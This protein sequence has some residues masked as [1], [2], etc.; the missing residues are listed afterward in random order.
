MKSRHQKY[1]AQ[2]MPL[3]P[4]NHVFVLSERH[5]NPWHI[6]QTIRTMS[7]QAGSIQ[8][9]Y[10]RYFIVRLFALLRY[11]DIV[12]ISD[13]ALNCSQKQSLQIESSLSN[14]R[15][16]LQPRYSPD[17]NQD[18]PWPHPRTR[19]SSKAPQAS[20]TRRNTQTS[21]SQ[22]RPAPSKPTKQSSAPNPPSSPPCPTPASKNPQPPP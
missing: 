12:L 7:S 11:K 8:A 5:D 6:E 17:Q 22:L 14:T 2:R 13:S 20:S 21:P 19:A 10:Q 16:P 15:K 18:L 3:W 1:F 4:Y 9:E